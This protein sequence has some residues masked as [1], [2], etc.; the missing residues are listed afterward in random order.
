MIFL[1]YWEDLTPAN[2]A[3]VL[4]VSEG[5]VRKQLSRARSKLREV[6]T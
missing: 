2:I 1:S 3:R 5:A 6:L 4:D